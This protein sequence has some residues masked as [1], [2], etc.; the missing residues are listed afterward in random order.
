MGYSA[1]VKDYW[2]RTY[3]SGFRAQVVVCI[4]ELLDYIIYKAV[5]SVE[6]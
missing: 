1:Q 4:K 2:C 5:C 6:S 3:N